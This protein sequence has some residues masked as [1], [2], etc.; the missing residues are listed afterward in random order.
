[1][2]GK[3]ISVEVVLDNSIFFSAASFQ[4]LHCHRVFAEVDASSAFE[5]VCQPVDDH[6]VEVIT[7]QMGVTVGREH[8][9]YTATE[10]ED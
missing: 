1:M 8:F 9:E 5:F 3:L 4:T 2:Y 6:L 10:F 7:T